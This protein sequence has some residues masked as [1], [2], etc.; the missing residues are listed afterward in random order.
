MTG[1]DGAAV[2][3]NSGDRNIGDIHHTKWQRQFRKDVL[4][5]F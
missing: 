1:L 4:K 5:R 2:N 3:G